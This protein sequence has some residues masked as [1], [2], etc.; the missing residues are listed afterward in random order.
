VL[1]WILDSERLLPMASGRLSARHDRSLGTSGLAGGRA[2]GVKALSPSA[3][4]HS[5]SARSGCRGGED[6]PELSFANAASEEDDG[7]G[8]PELDPSSVSRGSVAGATS[9]SG[10]LALD[11]EGVPL[12]AEVAS[13]LSRRD[14]GREDGDGDGTPGGDETADNEVNEAFAQVLRVIGSLQQRVQGSEGIVADLQ[15]QADELEEKRRTLARQA[16]RAERERDVAVE[17]S[18]K[19]EAAARLARSEAAPAVERFMEAEVLRSQLQVTSDEIVRLREEVLLCQEELTNGW[20]RLAEAEDAEAECATAIMEMERAH[21]DEL[22]AL[23]TLH[24]EELAELKKQHAVAITEM[25]AAKLEEVASLKAASAEELSSL[26]SALEAAR[27]EADVFRR[28]QQD[29]VRETCLRQRENARLAKQTSEARQEAIDLSVKLEAL[30]TAEAGAP[31]REAELQ[32]VRQR[33]QLLQRTAAEWG[34]AL[35]RKRIDC[36]SWRKWAVQRGAATQG[37]ALED[38]NVE[39]DLRHACDNGSDLGIQIASCG[40]QG[41][42]E[43]SLASQAGSTSLPASRPST[44]TLSRKKRPSAMSALSSSRGTA[45]RPASLHHNSSANAFSGGD[46]TLV[47]GE[48]LWNTQDLEASSLMGSTAGLSPMSVDRSAAATT[49]GQPWSG[50]PTPVR[51]QPRRSPATLSRTSRSQLQ[52]QQ[53]RQQQQQQ[54]QVRIGRPSR[55]SATEHQFATAHRASSSSRPVSARGWR[56][57]EARIAASPAP[58]AVPSL[59]LLAELGEREAERRDVPALPPPFTLAHSDGQVGGGRQPQDAAAE[60]LAAALRAAR[61]KVQAEEAEKEAGECNEDLKADLLEADNELEMLT[62]LL[63]EGEA[64][65]AAMLLGEE[66]VRQEQ[67]PQSGA[68]EIAGRLRSQAAELF[69]ACGT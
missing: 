7:D 15:A 48:D 54:Q 25:E 27:W 16:E 32:A 65:H 56:G 53:Q 41:C 51:T 5:S 37:E 47:L 44:P 39:D 64:E 22:E 52:Q 61:L 60:Y 66:A 30:K 46:S 6:S 35:E 12:P 34:E 42:E 21:A 18:E 8:A 2:R 4:S 29:L 11:V 24:A 58:S 31:A 49:P 1:L 40:E 43:D 20:P 69:A 3:G 33:Y 57:G 23:E 10:L 62:F 9:L 38:A 28:E 67:R 17:R 68:S 59:A 36:E 14:P 19:A 26:R 63:G 13:L 45:T 55:L 50:V